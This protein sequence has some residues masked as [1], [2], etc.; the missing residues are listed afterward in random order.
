MM[1]TGMVTDKRCEAQILAGKPQDS[2]R[3]KF[4]RNDTGNVHLRSFNPL[5]VET[6][7]LD[8]APPPFLGRW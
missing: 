2:E 8:K 1:Q 5:P 4:Y 3:A 7:F 6:S